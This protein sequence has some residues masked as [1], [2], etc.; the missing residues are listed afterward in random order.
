[1]HWLPPLD[2]FGRAIP[3]PPH[4]LF[5]W[6]MQGVRLL[7]SLPVGMAFWF[8]LLIIGA[9]FKTPDLAILVRIAPD[10]AVIAASL[11]A[12][13]SFFLVAMPQLMWP[14]TRRGYGRQLEARI[15]Q[16][17]ASMLNQQIEQCDLELDS[18]ASVRRRTTLAA[19]RHWLEAKRV[20]RTVEIT[21]QRQERLTLRPSRRKLITSAACGAVFLAVGLWFILLAI[22]GGDGGTG[23]EG[24]SG[25]NAVWTKSVIGGLL[26]LVTAIPLLEAFTVRVDLTAVEL[27][28]RGWGRILWSISRENVS[29][30]LGDDGSWLVLNA[31]TQKRIGELN[32]HH[33]ED[34]ELLALVGRLRPLG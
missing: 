24:F 21:P 31:R 7:L 10:M 9:A 14:W 5:S 18:A 19:W 11:S 29:L 32:P 4:H 2:H 12:L 16:M 22:L 6:R 28:K 25:P 23:I 8:A 34:G 15:E 1:M 27:R 13:F 33:F 3:V 30:A 17:S 26:V 20:A